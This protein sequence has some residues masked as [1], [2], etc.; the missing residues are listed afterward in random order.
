MADIKVTLVLPA[1][2][3]KN[4]EVADDIPIQELLPELVTALSI[5]T[6]GP[7]GQPMNYRLTNKA[8]G[9]ALAET[10]T[11]NSAGVNEGDSLLMTMVLVPGN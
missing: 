6:L 3:T 11:L 9:K 10:D 4:L 7:D 1:G 5:P 2:E 8:S